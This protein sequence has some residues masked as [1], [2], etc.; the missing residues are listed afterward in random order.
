VLLHGVET[1]DLWWIK[2]N[3]L[4]EFRECFGRVAVA[5]VKSLIE[6]ERLNKHKRP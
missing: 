1:C 4:D 6:A 2:Q 5:D 3:D